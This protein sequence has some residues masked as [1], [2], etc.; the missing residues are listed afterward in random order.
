MLRKRE[1]KRFASKFVTLKAN[2]ANLLNRSESQA[3]KKRKFSPSLS[4]LT[5]SDKICEGKLFSLLSQL[6]MINSYH[7][8]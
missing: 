2:I 1:K 4:N 7:P 5:T 8:E 3:S 6:Y